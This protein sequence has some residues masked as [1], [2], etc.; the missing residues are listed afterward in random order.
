MQIQKKKRINHNK[1]NRSKIFLIQKEFR[2]L[3]LLKNLQ[4]PRWNIQQ[5]KRPENDYINS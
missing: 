2:A 1:L 4:N 5:M 3:K